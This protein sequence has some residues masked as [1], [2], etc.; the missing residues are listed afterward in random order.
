M[1][2]EV[3]VQPNASTKDKGDLLENL[4][5]K[6]LQAQSYKVISEI[7]FTAVELDLLCKHTVSGREIYVECKAHRDNIDANVLKNLAGTLMFKNYDEGWLITTAPLG[8]EAKGFVKEWEEKEKKSSANLS[9]YTP[10]R[11]IDSLISSGTIKPPPSDAAEKI[12]GSAN[13]LGEWTLSINS[14]G[15]YWLCTKLAGGIPKEVIGFYASNSEP[16]VDSELLQKISQ[17]DTTLTELQFIPA[18]KVLELPLELESSTD[19]V[20]VQ[21]GDSWEDYRPSR[22]QD[23][24]GR[25]KDQ[26]AVFDL[27][28]S[29]IAQKTATRIFAF[30]G[31][32]G[33]GKSS[34]IAKI[35][36]KGNSLY[37][38]KKIFVYPVD[39]RAAKSQSYIY[40]SLLRTLRSAQSAGFGSP[41][42]ELNITDVNSP[43]SSQSVKDFLN[44]VEKNGQLIVLIL[45]QFEELYTKPELYDVFERAKSLLLSCAAFGG[46]F[47]LGFA[48]KSDSTTPNEHPAYFF[49]HELADYRMTRKLAPFSDQDSFAALNIFEKQIKQRL[50]NDLRHNLLVS[51][52]GYPWLLK[53]LCIHLFEKIESG[54][55]QKDLLENKLDVRNL[56]DSDLNQLTNS[57][58]ACL[59][60]VAQRA[61][62]DWFD[63]S[64]T[65]TVETL[66][67]LVNRRLII[68]SGDRLN[69]YW[70]IFREYLLTGKVPIIPLRYLP[71]TDF[72]SVWRV[73]QSLNYNQAITV[74]EIAI[75]TGFSEGTVQNIG[76]DI[77]MFGLAFREEGTYQLIPEI[78]ATD[79]LS[80]SRN[81]REKFTKHA[82]LLALQARPS[83]N[84]I[85][86]AEAV[87]TL[88]EIFP[89]NSYASNTWH[90]YTIRLCRWLELCGFIVTVQN[91][92][93]YR[94]RGDVIEMNAQTRPR[95]VGCY[96]PLTSPDVTLKCLEI[97]TVSGMIKFEGK[98]PRGYDGSMRSLV[99]FNLAIE[100]EK[101]Y[102]PCSKNLSTFDSLETALGAMAAKEP[103]I[104]QASQILS[105]RSSMSGKELGALFNLNFKL[106]WSE[107]TQIRYGRPLKQ[108]V[109]WLSKF[110]SA[111]EI[112][113]IPQANG[114]PKGFLQVDEVP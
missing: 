78:D 27:F 95:Q 7:R 73:I 2:I 103:S 81:V 53:K 66:N 20:K 3:A 106:N 110:Q 60:F 77:N 38:G 11:V 19:V 5:V 97:L 49:W 35:A 34:L 6:L 30:T 79:V 54:I 114:N 71:S 69:V 109:E 14:Y 74:A 56:F 87:E 36:D 83:N 59:N 100:Q 90:V 16:V 17:T 58:R 48:W 104:I 80:L 94:D 8:K 9:F 4:A 82:F 44:V 85:T 21:Y 75:Q 65:S 96:L 61:P 41:N 113:P 39:I 32:S 31:D 76:T 84:L 52:Q 112:S 33:M 86:M 42:I 51:S 43:L 98:L 26:A 45:D 92:W 10:E 22:P 93:V 40:S 24:V 72:A 102:Y 62:V 67:S 12:V 88:K 18:R 91:G 99:R 105:S 57:E 68:K 50:D 55:E 29:I 111:D 23:F 89:N 64:E 37:N 15:T 25:S 47:C 1:R 108:W 63:V 101:N 46:N 13:L 70:D 107:A 28:R